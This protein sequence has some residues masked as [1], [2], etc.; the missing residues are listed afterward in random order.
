MQMQD[1][2]TYLDILLNE[3][4]FTPLFNATGCP[5]ASIP[6]GHSANGL[7]VGVQLGAAFGNEALLLRVAGELETSAPWHQRQ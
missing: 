1:W 7:P 3:I 4:P 2:H 5:A 6:F